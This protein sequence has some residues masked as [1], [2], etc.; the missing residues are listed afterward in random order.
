MTRGGKSFEKLRMVIIFPMYFDILSPPVV[1][2]PE[3]TLYRDKRLL[4]G[5]YRP[6]TAQLHLMVREDEVR[7]PS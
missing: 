2:N 7:P 3:C 4:L 6:R 5:V 1:L